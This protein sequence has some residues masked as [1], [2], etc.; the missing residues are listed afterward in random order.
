MFNILTADSRRLV[1]DLRHLRVHLDAEVLG[2][3]HLLVPG[4]DLVLHPLA[5][6]VLQQS[7]D[8]IGEPLLWDLG[9]LEVRLRQI[10]VDKGVMIVE[11]LA[12]LLHAQSLVLRNVD[13][14]DLRRAEHLLGAVH[15]LLQ[16]YIVSERSKDVGII[17]LVTYSRWSHDLVPAGRYPHR[18]LESYRSHVCID[19]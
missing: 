1:K 13:G 15:Q 4:L 7:C 19:H 16:D 6:L 12:D 18:K 10:L 14:P 11:E 5:E 3:G 2:H 8:Y 9:Q 17:T